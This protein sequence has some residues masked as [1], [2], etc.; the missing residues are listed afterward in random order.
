MFV[1]SFARW[2]NLFMS[3]ELLRPFFGSKCLPDVFY[4]QTRSRF[5]RVLFC[6]PNPAMAGRRTLNST[7]HADQR[8][9]QD[10]AASTLMALGT[11]VNLFSDVIIII[12]FF[13]SINFRAH[14]ASR[15]QIF[16][17]LKFRA[18]ERP[19]EAMGGQWIV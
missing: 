13:L 3:G 2:K 8:G 12:Y 10:T 18:I 6:E 19:R 5:F 15:S 17:R 14:Y 9:I 7:C 4:F 16:E 1:F 11:R